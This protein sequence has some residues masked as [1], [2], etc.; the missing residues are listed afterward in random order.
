MEGFR[1]HHHRLLAIKKASGFIAP[2]LSL[3]LHF[4]H[5]RHKVIDLG[6]DACVAA[7][8]QRIHRIGNEFE[9]VSLKRRSLAEKLAA[10]REE[11]V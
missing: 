2:R 3:P 9:G 5:P 10:Y 11:E 4:P 8:L 6:C 1:G 7:R